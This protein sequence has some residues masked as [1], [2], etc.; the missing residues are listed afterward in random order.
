MFGFR[1]N[2]GCTDFLD[3]TFATINLLK[4]VIGELLR[5]RVQ[6]NTSACGGCHTYEL[7]LCKPGAWVGP[8]EFD[9]FAPAHT[10]ADVGCDYLRQYCNEVS[11]IGVRSRM[12]CPA[13]CGC[14]LP[15]SSLA[16]SLPLS[17]CPER[18]DRTVRY[19]IALA[20]MPC[21]DV[22]R[23][24]PVFNE[25]LDNWQAAA[26]LWPQAWQQIT[27]GYVG[28][29]KYEGCDFIASATP[30]A[31]IQP[32]FPASGGQAIN[33]CVENG[34]SV[35]LK[36]LSIFCPVACGCRAGDNDCPDSCPARGRPLEGNASYRVVAYHALEPNYI[37]PSSRVPDYVVPA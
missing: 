3:G 30:P 9:E 11:D 27:N 35:P 16:L 34:A 32:S 15:R 28:L 24:D 31:D 14:D 23:E 36:A 18:C 17:G 22:D 37:L 4:S 5:N 20:E 1:W 8:N 21:Q 2:P 29:L 10:C 26:Q 19:K 6:L 33:V 13:T 7:P 12:L 25:F